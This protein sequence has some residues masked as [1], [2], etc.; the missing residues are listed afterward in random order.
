MKYVS[1]VS[2]VSRARFSPLLALQALPMY[3]MF[4]IAQISLIA[5]CYNRYD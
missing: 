1:L 5:P 4:I 2:G 3:V